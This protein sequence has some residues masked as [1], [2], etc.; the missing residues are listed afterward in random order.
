MQAA[1]ALRNNLQEKGPSFTALDD[2]TNWKQAIPGSEA[3][4]MLNWACTPPAAEHHARSTAKPSPAPA[5]ASSAPA[6]A[7][8]STGT[9]LHTI[10]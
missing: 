9:N 10:Q 6:D 5:K 4:A 3:D 2:D 8:A 7:P 1:L